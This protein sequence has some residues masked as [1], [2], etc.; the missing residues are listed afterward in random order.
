MRSACCLLLRYSSV[1]KTLA[2]A[3]LRSAGISA[4]GG[5][6]QE[7]G[8]VLGVEGTRKAPL[9]GVAGERGIVNV[10]CVNELHGYNKTSTAVTDH[11]MRGN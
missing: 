5:Y 8:A 6:S 9:D 11:E 10:T 1:A 7:D 4:E 3:L 2:L